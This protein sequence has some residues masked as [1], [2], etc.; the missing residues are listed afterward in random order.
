VSRTDVA[1]KERNRQILE[2]LNK[3]PFVNDEKLAKHFNV[4]INTIRLDRA[5]LGIKEVRER[6]KERASENEKKIIS[7][8]KEEIIG[9]IIEFVPGEKAISLLETQE[10]MSFENTDVIKGYHIYSMAESLAISLIPNKV[11]LVGIANIKYVKKIIKN[12]IIYAHAEVKKK[13]DTNYIV[14]VKIFDRND[15]LKFKG[16]F[17]LKGIE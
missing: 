5:R 2:Y 17:I 3:E 10:Y 13:R 7:L 6:I 16:K 4:S 14:W 12:E 9:N 8:S 1:R 11:A 15:E